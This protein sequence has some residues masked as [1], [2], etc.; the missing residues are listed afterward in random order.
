MSQC[1]D[2]GCRTG[3]IPSG[4]MEV[5]ELTLDYFGKSTKSQSNAGFSLL[6]AGWKDIFVDVCVLHF[7][8]NGHG[9]HLIWQV[10]LS[11]AGDIYETFPFE[12]RYLA[13]QC[14]RTRLGDDFCFSSQCWP[15]LAW[16]VS[17]QD[18]RAARGTRE[19]W[20]RL[21]WSKTR[22][23]GQRLHGGASQPNRSLLL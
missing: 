18:C 4:R 7:G 5:V 1:W 14:F 2:P 19:S 11:E 21:E 12:I 8:M 20:N 22:I 10:G 15:A 16:Q 6:Y 23:F 3:S 9:Y 13:R 17:S